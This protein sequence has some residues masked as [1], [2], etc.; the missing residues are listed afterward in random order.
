MRSSGA[1]PADRAVRKRHAARNSRQRARTAPPATQ[2]LLPLKGSGTPGR[3]KRRPAPSPRRRELLAREK[4]RLWERLEADARRIAAQ[5]RLECSRLEPEREGVRS[6]YGITYGDGTIRIR[7]RHAATGRSLKYSS[8]VNTV[9]HELA[10]LRHF[11]HG[12]RFKK[13]YFRILEWARREGIYRP[14]TSEPE[15]PG[16]MCLFDDRPGAGSRDAPPGL[17][18]SPARPGTSGPGSGAGR[19]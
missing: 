14:S 19:R 2:L 9:C 1:R 17:S 4:A 12:E 3:G 5:F 6:H 10:H 11:N 15:L 18:R 16:Q 8:L 13:F 7:L